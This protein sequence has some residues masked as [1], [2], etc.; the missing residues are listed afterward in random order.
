MPGPE[1]NKQKLA[2]FGR[3][4][5]LLLNRATMYKADHPYIKQSIDAVYKTIHPLLISVTPLVFILNGEQFYIDKESLDPRLN[6]TRTLTHFKQTGIQSI[7]FD[8]GLAKNELKVFLE[9]FSSLNQYPDVGAMKNALTAKNITHLKINHV[10][11]KK[12]TEDE[13]V[14]SR[15]A[16][17]KVTSQIM[18]EPQLKSKEVLVDALLQSVLTEEFSKTMNIGNLMKDPVGLSRNMIDTDLAGSR[19]SE[20]ENQQPGPILLQQLEMIGQEVEKSFTGERDFNLSKLAD[21]VFDMKKQLIDGIKAQKALGIAYPNEEMIVKKT[22]EIGDKVIIRL[23]KEEYHAGKISTVRLA[24]ILRRL[25][26]ETDELKRLLPRIKGAL[27]KEGM[28]L[29]EYYNLM[30]ELA[31]ELQNEELARILKES[32][33]EI[34]IDGEGLIQEVKENPVQAAELMYLASEIRKGTGDEKVLTEILV[35]YV[36][37]LGLKMTVDMAKENGVEGE[38]H[39]R[40]VMS[41][42]ESN[43]VR[44]LGAMDLKEDALAGLEEKIKERMDEMVEN[45]SVQW[46]HSQ[47]ESIEETRPIQL[48]V[49]ETL[50]RSVSEKGELGKI[51]KIVRSRV[52][53]KK[54]DEN[55]FKQIHKEIERQNQIK[56]DKKDKKKLPP[57]V[58]K[59]ESLMFFLK[60][61]I[62]RVKRYDT[63]F[64]ILAFSVLKAKAK[65]PSSSVHVT[66]EALMDAV[67]H[68]FSDIFR[69]TDVVSQ[70]EQNN[71]VALLPMTPQKEGKLALRRVLRL[72]NLES[73]KVNGIPIAFKIVGVANS[74]DP[75]NIPDA[76]SV[77]KT[78]SNELRYMV[79]RIKNIHQFF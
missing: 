19:Q 14:V 41:G 76:K 20:P 42:V 47:S 64:T 52:E 29:S 56:K 9:V 74:A 32:S 13:E 38:K 4:L 39:L 17:K 51:L 24:Q 59:P 11:F 15:D 34:G 70:F 25:V 65:S 49:L 6:V 46:F 45:L 66:K 16:L 61:E 68:K 57:G 58:V 1:V 44:Q 69:E 27:L 55:D 30:E 28:P 8:R 71:I 67:L 53:S 77:V 75:E 22:S 79:A 35:D 63:P 10:F 2:H 73:I 60:Q 72:L 26:P 5:T 54:I 37:R 23:I 50:E 7:S 78:L 48:S 31:T 62:A 33:Q 18:E 40:Q 36:E 43:I 12:M 21:A 3:N